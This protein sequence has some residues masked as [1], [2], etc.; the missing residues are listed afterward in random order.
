M[1]HKSNPVGNEITCVMFGIKDAVLNGVDL[2]EKALMDCAK[3]ENFKILKK[4]SHRFEP[5]G[6]TA[7]LLIQESHIAVH[8]YP[9]YNCLV[10]NLYSCRSPED[11]RKSLEFFKKAVN[12][13]KIT[14][15][16]NQ[17]RI[18]GENGKM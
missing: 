15:R 6:Y 10:F 9:E 3:E 7:I 13:E 18:D 4:I 12:P 14:L 17:V 2:L 11:G 1:T 8:T 16:E 5:R